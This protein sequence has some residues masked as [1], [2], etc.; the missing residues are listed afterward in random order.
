MAFSPSQSSP[1]EGL[2]HIRIADILHDRQVVFLEANIRIEDALE[3]LR[4]KKIL[5]CPVLDLVRGHYIGWLDMSDIVTFILGL[6]PDVNQSNITPKCLQSIDLAS[7]HFAATPVKEVLAVATQEHPYEKEIKPVKR[8]TLLLDVIDM[9]YMGL[10]RIAVVDDKNHIFN[11]ISQTDVLAYL[12]QNIHLIREKAG[13]TLKEFK[14]GVFEGLVSVKEDDSMIKV[15]MTLYGKRISAVPIVDGNGKLIATFST[16][17]LKGM[18]K[19]NFVDLLLPV[20]EFLTKR[21]KDSPEPLANERVFY[22]FTVTLDT[23][24]PDAICRMVATRVHRL[25]C[26]D[27]VGRVIGVVSMTDVMKVFLDYTQK[28]ASC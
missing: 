18:N 2:K 5:S 21:I 20:K 28:S 14:L 24:L 3:V 22:P 27:D 26:V 10:H 11:L 12:A 15:L 23:T 17:D 16:S 8:E 7:H 4:E 25:W 6:Y 13:H 1:V 9:F 19:D